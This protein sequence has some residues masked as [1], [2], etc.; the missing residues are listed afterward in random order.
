MNCDPV[1][2]WA[3]TRDV[4]RDKVRLSRNEQPGLCH[5]QVPSPPL[6]QGESLSI[7]KRTPTIHQTPSPSDGDFK[8]FY[9]QRELDRLGNG[10]YLEIGVRRWESLG[11]VRGRRT[12]IGVDPSARWRCQPCLPGESFYAMTSDQFFEES[13]AVQSSGQPKSTWPSL[14]VCTN[15]DQASCRMSSTPRSGCIQRE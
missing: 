4:N 8:E 7:K 5:S 6:E 3:S 13:A 14:T 10:V 9:V 15:M 11:A 1:A 12:R 2:D